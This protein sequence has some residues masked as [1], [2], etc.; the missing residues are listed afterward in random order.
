MS[1]PLDKYGFQSVDWKNVTIDVAQDILGQY[2]NRL[3]TSIKNFEMVDGKGRYGLTGLIGLT[4]ALLAY[5]KGEPNA[6]ITVLVIGFILA[7]ICFAISLWTRPT[8]GTGVTT[9]DMSLTEWSEGMI[10][11]H[12]RQELIGVVICQY[13][14]NIARNEA[15]HKE[16]AIWINRGLALTLLGLAAAFLVGFCNV[17]G[18]V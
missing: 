2:R 13:A 3:D 5:S 17:T 8:S 14:E 9:T 15:T 4:T 7:A 18:I 1:T 16:K 10:N 11:P 12:A 6:S